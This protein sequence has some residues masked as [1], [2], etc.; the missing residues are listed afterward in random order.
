MDVWLFILYL[1]RCVMK[2]IS[3]LNFS[4]NNLAAVISKIASVYSSADKSLRRL[5]DE[6]F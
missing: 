2:I 1:I 4:P 3:H 6:C 5:S